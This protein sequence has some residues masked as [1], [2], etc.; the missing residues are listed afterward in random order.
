MHSLLIMAISYHF[1]H[2]S[3]NISITQFSLSQSK[4][5]SHLFVRYLKHT[6][7]K[8]LLGNCDIL[9]DTFKSNS[10]FQWHHHHP[11]LVKIST[12]RKVKALPVKQPPYTVYSLLW[13][14][15]GLFP[16]LNSFLLSFCLKKT[17]NKIYSTQNNLL[18]RSY[19]ICEDEY[20]RTAL[21]N[22]SLI[23]MRDLMNI[24]QQVYFL[25]EVEGAS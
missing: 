17:E 4:F 23:I 24:R 7:E 10:G 16:R 1:D 2:R 9:I 19:G 11:P 3:L 15:I 12:V 18:S 20:L 25:L 5:L 21:C 22:K 8:Q 13:E 6:E 14:K